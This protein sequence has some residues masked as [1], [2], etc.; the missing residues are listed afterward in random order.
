MPREKNE[1]HKDRM[2]AHVYQKLAVKQ[3]IFIITITQNDT[4]VKTVLLLQ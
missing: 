4:L 2:T 3:M 1:F